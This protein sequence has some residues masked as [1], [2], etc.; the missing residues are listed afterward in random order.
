MLPGRS[1]LEEDNEET[2][3]LNLNAMNKTP[4][5]WHVSFSYGKAL[6]KTCIV[7]WMGKDE[8]VKAA[9]AALLARSKANFEA[10][11]GI[12]V[13]GSCSSVGA[14]GN[15]EMAGGAY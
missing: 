14:K 7:T 13:A 1:Q 10:A 4:N 12:Y 5:P 8:N 15:I 11:K 6:Q 2:A 9:Q 3:T